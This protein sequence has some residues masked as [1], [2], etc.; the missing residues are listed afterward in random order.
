[1]KKLIGVVTEDPAT[2]PPIG[3]TIEFKPAPFPIGSPHGEYT[4][5]NWEHF[6]GVLLSLVINV[7]GETYVHGSGVLV[8]PGVALAA[9]HVVEPFF[10]V[11]QNESATL[12]CTS[13]TENQLML[14]KC[15]NIHII[16]KE[17]DIVVLILNYC[18]DFPPGNIFR[19]AAITT[20]MPDLGEHVTMVGF[21]VNEITSS[22][23]NPGF[24]VSGHVRTSTGI[25]TA[26][27]PNGR[28]R[29]MMPGP[30]LE[31]NTSASGGMSGGPV[32]DQYGHLVGLVSTSWSADDH[33]GPTTIS[34]LWPILVSPINAVWPNGV[35]V[36]G[37]PLSEFGP[38]C[39]ID[40]SDAIERISEHEIAYTPWSNSE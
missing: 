40:R 23:Q 28:D 7:N 20:R 19:M 37:R 38:L 9:R 32:F 12:T 15:H 27:Y 24:S 6:G 2:D 1:M 22:L 21:T 3:T 4:I 14:W 25:I 18:S 39:W 31:I 17:L 8:A 13:I 35:H 11:M 34:L 10:D 36:P 29:V 33:I 16:S 30:A 26:C 5:D